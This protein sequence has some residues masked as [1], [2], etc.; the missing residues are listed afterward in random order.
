[1]FTWICPKCGREVPP[2]YNDCPNCAEIAA[3][4]ALTGS[5][6]PPGVVAPPQQ[7]QQ[8]ALPPGP[9]GGRRPLWATGPQEAMPPAPPPSFA[10]PQP[11][12]APAPA[13]PPEAPPVFRPQ[14]SAS[15]MFQ[16][17]PPQPPPYEPPAF[18][19][20]QSMSPMFQAPPPQAPQYVPP[21]PPGNPTWLTGVAIGV[22][23]VMAVLA[24]YWFF[25][26]SQSTSAGAETTA[27]AATPAAAGENPVTKFVEVAGVRFSPMT[28]GI[29]ISFVLINHAD[30]DLVGLKG[31]ATILAKTNKGEEIPLGSVKFET[32]MG[33]QTSKELTLPF[34][35]KKKMVDMPD[36]Q[37]VSVK[38]EIT[39]PIGS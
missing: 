36:W 8:G 29:Q 5:A 25:G 30:Q 23:V 39:S 7:S 27:A 32:A 28:K 1:M 16:P 12:S 34:D 37:N 26:R 11:P 24:V 14:Q 4:G 21:P 19:P 17:S 22:I 13:L 33:A 38:V 6:T 2:A 31:S 15:P 10:P 20:P 35:T 18:R 3:A 9:R